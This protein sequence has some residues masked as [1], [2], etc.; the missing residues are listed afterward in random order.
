M[1]NTDRFT[2]DQKIQILLSQ[3]N[4]RNLAWHNMRDRS[5]RFTI[6]ILGLSIAASWQLLQQPCDCTWQKFAVTALI[7]ILG[8][9]AL[10]FLRGLSAG[11]SANRKVLIN[12]EAALGLYDEGA[13]LPGRSLFPSAYKDSKASLN[14]HFSTLYILITAVCV[15]LLIAVWLPIQIQ[16]T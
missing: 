6:W 14:D 11:A 5:M 13:F 8:S 3:M 2:H 12:I 1:D 7:V 9:A 4:E 15:F 10:H 16:S